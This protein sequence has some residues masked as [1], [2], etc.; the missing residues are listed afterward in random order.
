M[1]NPKSVGLIQARRVSLT[2]TGLHKMIFLTY[3]LI[4]DTLTTAEKI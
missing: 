3:F 2:E 1:G 4:G